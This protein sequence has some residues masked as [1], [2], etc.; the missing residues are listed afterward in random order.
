MTD[1]T[2]TV[3]QIANVGEDP[4]WEASVAVDKIATSDTITISSFSGVTSGD[5]VCI[6]AAMNT[7]DGRSIKLCSDGSSVIPGV[8]YGTALRQFT[9]QV[10]HLNSSDAVTIRYRRPAV[11]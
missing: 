8:S 3:K 4:V 11:Q 2:P 1:H 9:I 7:T 6:D 10:G 5:K